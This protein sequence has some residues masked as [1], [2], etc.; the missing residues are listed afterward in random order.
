MHFLPEG[1]EI[2][3]V[4]SP[5]SKHMLI[6]YVCENALSA[7]AV[8]CEIVDMYSGKKK[9]IYWKYG[10]EY[11]DITWMDDFTVRINNV[12]LNINSDIYDWRHSE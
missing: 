4:L 10:E 12:F 7:P 9:N 1:K 3:H 11:V 5:D 8:R 6:A 2:D